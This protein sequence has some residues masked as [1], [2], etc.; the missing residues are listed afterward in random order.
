MQVTGEHL[1]QVAHEVRGCMTPG[2]TQALVT[3][4]LRDRDQADS[5]RWQVNHQPCTAG[6]CLP[7]CCCLLCL[8]LLWC[9]L[10]MHAITRKS[11]AMTLMCV[12][13][14][15]SIPHQVNLDLAVQALIGYMLTPPWVCMAQ[16]AFIARLQPNQV[17]K[18]PG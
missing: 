8:E 16:I 7:A 5:D 3:R 18:A 6:A 14:F 15:A 1:K 13:A 2:G 11:N 4:E 10:V 17:F 9:L 12:S